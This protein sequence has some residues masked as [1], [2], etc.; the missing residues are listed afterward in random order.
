MIRIKDYLENEKSYKIDRKY[1]RPEGVWS[2]E[3]MQ[4]LIDTILNGDPMP[5][6]VINK[7]GKYNYIVD[8]Q[9]R[10]YC[11][12]QFC[13]NKF[14]LSEKIFDD[15]EKANK[16]FKNLNKDLKS[17]ILDY[18]LW[19]HE[20]VDVDDEKIRAVFSKL[21][22]GKPLILGEKINAMPG[23]IVETIRSLSKHKVFTNNFSKDNKRYQHYETVVRLMM[24]AKN[25]IKDLG[26]RTINSFMSENKDLKYNNADIK[27]LVNVLN[28]ISK[29]YKKDNSIEDGAMFTS[30]YSFVDVLKKEYVIEKKT[31][32]IY[33]FLKEF[34]E[35]IYDD[36]LKDSNSNYRRYFEHK[37][38]FSEKDNKE[39]LR[40]LLEEFKNSKKYFT[41]IK[42]IDR[43]IS[44]KQKRMVFKAFNHKCANCKKEFNKYN[45]VEYHHVT[46]YA[47]G[48]KTATS[49]IV[50]LC[51]KCH[52]KIHKS[53]IKFDRNKIKFSK[54]DYKDNE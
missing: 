17:K 30:I 15:E 36:S 20:L 14:K 45:D 22:R 24:L 2:S 39:R 38:R 46:K 28:F 50:P 29:C 34:Y 11:I 4:Y 53:E 3:D 51:K 37:S 7:K 8:G 21:Q 41:G 5:L 12:S 31:D 1:Q 26:V 16:Y 35:N 52:K 9:Q 27:Y 13:H 10:L 33:K 6:F 49:N 19:I 18:Q 47:E 44:S 32:K 23:K 54:D 42:D 43:Q 40:I 25:G 48:G